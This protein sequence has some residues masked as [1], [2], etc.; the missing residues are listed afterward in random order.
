V[1]E[2]NSLTVGLVLF[3]MAHCVPEIKIFMQ[4]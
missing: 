2:L 1:L 3:D 4:K